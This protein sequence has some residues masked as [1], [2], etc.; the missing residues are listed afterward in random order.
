MKKSLYAICIFLAA[1]IS[2]VAQNYPRCI[3]AGDYA[4]P[5]IMR[6]G[7][8]FYLTHSMFNYNPGFLIWHSQD[9]VNW[10]PVCRVATKHIVD[11]WAP[12]LLKHN[13]KYYLYFP[14]Q[15][16]VFVCIADRV[17]G[18]WSE[19]IEVKGTVG[20]DPGHVVS[21]EGKRY[22]FVNFGRMAPLN[23]EGTALTDTMRVVHKGW[24][25]PKQWVTEGKYPI[26]YLESPKLIHHNGY[27]YLTSAEGGTAGPPTSHMVVSAR[28]KSL[29][30]PWEE[31][32]YNPIIHTYSST[33]PWW[34]KGHG[35][36]IDDAEGNWWI[37]YHAYANNY[38]SLGRQTL[39]E[40]VEF[41]PDGWFRSVRNQQLPKAEKAIKHGFDLNDDFKSDTLGLQWTFYKEYAQE[42]VSVGNG[43][44]VLNGKGTD[45]T[46][47]R[48]MPITAEDKGYDVECEV[49]LTGKEAGLMLFYSEKGFSGLTSD[50][51]NLKLYH[52]GELV[53]QIPN[54]L[55]KKFSI[56]LRNLGNQ[57]TVQTKKS[58]KDN[59]WTTLAKGLDLTDL[60][61]NKL[62]GFVALRPG[63]VSVGKGKN[64]FMHF[65][66]KSHRP[67]EADMKAYLMVYHK[68]E[69]HGLHMAI[70]RD[71]R[72]FKALNN[73]NPVIAGDT[74]ARQ[75]G[76]RDPHIYRGTDG[77]F[78]MAMTDLHVFARRDG[79]RKDEWERPGE[80]YGW[81]NNRGLVLM[82]MF[83]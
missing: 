14:S 79:K 3:L 69:D 10:E 45:V 13:G 26:T 8:D 22:L 46:N 56:R 49:N 60:N 17:E 75:L 80:E 62:R 20:I 15:N 53:K 66:Y 18:P 74:I 54:K 33:E 7:K 65:R 1:V 76:V 6:D 37:V 36:L 25:I 24:E 34:S 30:G 9:L 55:G 57:L 50:G 81:G 63:V 38:H 28:A 44:M 43:K 78:Y 64:E 61:H 67:D 5:S 4:D 21:S 2:A 41:T 32:P 16:K 58:E 70:S 72:Q 40:P 77:A 52:K 48:Y 29:E 12:D 39:I 47:G 59:K 19:P 68:D 27:Y 71:G 73:D 51:K 23:D 35:T 31:S 83:M 11:A 82:K 42:A